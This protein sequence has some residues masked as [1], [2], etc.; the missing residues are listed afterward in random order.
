MVMKRST[1]KINRI[2]TQTYLVINYRC[3]QHQSFWQLLFAES[4]YESKSYKCENN[5]R[6]Q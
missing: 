2:S 3:A 6:K 4:S 1:K 5:D